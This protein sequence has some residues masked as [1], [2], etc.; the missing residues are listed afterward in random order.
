[1][2]LLAG[3]TLAHAQEPDTNI[4]VNPPPAQQPPPAAQ[5]TVIVAQ[6]TPAEDRVVVV[7]SPQ[8]VAAESET[9]TTEVRSNVIVT[10]ALTFGISYGIAAFAAAESD[11]DSD[12]RMYVPLLG[13][14]LAL[15]DRGDCPVD[16]QSCD[17]ETTDKVLMVIDGVFQA[18]GVVTAVYGVLS[19]R[20]VTVHHSNSA[21][22]EVHMVPLSMGH[23]SS[24]GFGLAGTF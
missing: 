1:V 12:K 7:S 2:A 14:W 17:S 19:P 21:K 22:R 24:A 3:P 8:A 11:R 18:A 15:A 16:Q 13:P 6:P 10:G 9:T 20:T 23:G 5:P 4:T